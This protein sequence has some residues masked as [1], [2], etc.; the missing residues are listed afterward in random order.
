MAWI[1]IDSNNG[2]RY[3]INTNTITTIEG[4]DDTLI[5]RMADGKELAFFNEDR[6]SFL[7][8]LERKLNRD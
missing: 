7:E 5:V 4:G 2:P 3:L 8:Q 6:Q 1:T